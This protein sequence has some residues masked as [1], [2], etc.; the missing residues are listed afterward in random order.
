MKV[1]PSIGLFG[2]TLPNNFSD[3]RSGLPTGMMDGR[4]PRALVTKLMECL[5]VGVQLAEKAGR[6]ICGTPEKECQRIALEFR[7]PASTGHIALL[8]YPVA[9]GDHL[10]GIGPPVAFILANV[11]NVK[12]CNVMVVELM[13]HRNW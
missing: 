4:S 10:Q 7:H 6:C 8:L 12:I 5:Y 13:W 1:Y 3:S 9:Q 11:S 2:N